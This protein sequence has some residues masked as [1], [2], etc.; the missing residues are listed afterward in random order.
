[1]NPES[2]TVRMF[3]PLAHETR[4]TVE[5]ECAAFHLNRRPQTLRL[6]ACQENG[7]IRPIHVHG[8]LA[9]KVADIQAVLNGEIA[10]GDSDCET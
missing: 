9:W 7:P 4:L 2:A 8:R 3:P 10:H 5:T 6:W 1:M